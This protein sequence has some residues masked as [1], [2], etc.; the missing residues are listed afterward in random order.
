MSSFRMQM[1]EDWSK[2]RQ[3]AFSDRIHLFWRRWTICALL[4]S[5]ARWTSQPSNGASFTCGGTRTISDSTPTKTSPFSLTFLT[6]SK[7]SATNTGCAHHVWMIS[8]E[9]ANSTARR[10]GHGNANGVP[11]ARQPF[12]AISCDYRT[13]GVAH[14]PA[15]Q[16]R[17]EAWSRFDAV[18]ACLH[19]GNPSLVVHGCAR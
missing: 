5:N 18:A 6:T 9:Y 12:R 17:S 7:G 10:S 4:G 14:G 1:G 19:D 2:W 15:P 11:P 8:H 16:P 3:A 13:T